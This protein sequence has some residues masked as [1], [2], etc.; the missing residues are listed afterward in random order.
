MRG[1]IVNLCIG[2]MNV[3]LGVLIIIY[4][5]KIPQDKTLITV[6]ENIVIEYVL[7]ATYA[8]IICAALIN[9]VQSYHHRTDSTFNVGYL[10]GIFSISFLFI[11]HP[12][13]GAFNLISGIV[14][15]IKSLKENLIE[16]NSTTAISISIVMIAAIAIIGLA[17]YNY[18]ILGNTI[19]NRENKNELSYKSDYFKYITELGIDDVYINVKKDGKF[20]YI[21]QNGECVISFEYDYA[22]PF[23]EITAYDK[24]FHIALVCKDGST[25]IILKNKREVMSYRTE[26]ADDNYEKK[27]E[28]LKDVYI[29]KLDQKEPMKYEIESYNSNKN[30]VEAYNDFSEDYTFRYD[31]NDEYDVIVTQSNMG[32]GDKFEFAKKED[33]NIRISLNATHLDYDENYLYLFSDGTIPFYEPSKKNQGWFTSFGQKREIKGNAQILEI[34]DERILIKNCGTNEIYFANNDGEMLSEIYKDIFVCQDGRFIVKDE[35]GY[36]KVIDNEYK[37]LFDKKYAVINTRLVSENLYLVLDTTSNIKFNDYGY[38]IM[39]WK[40]MNY[41][42]E[43]IMDGIEEI[44]DQILELPDEKEIDEENYL[45]FENNLR[46]LNYEFVG[47][48]FYSN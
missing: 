43:I 40:L 36:L 9:L 8:V 4:T 45:I 3:L 35:S 22:S 33:L 12:V 27:L 46:E 32:F 47:D 23:V 28:E 17:A 13:I 2:F 18:D 1:K 20:G 16:L 21:N 44:Y 42:G 14:V 5:Q 15:L 48:K 29:N 39:N 24:K 11:K 30:K 7:L 41:N 10:L 19:K 26:S 34:F 37:H 38:A 6:Q 25:T 31:Y